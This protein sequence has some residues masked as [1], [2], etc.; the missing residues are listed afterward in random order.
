MKEKPEQDADLFRQALEGVTPL[1]PPDRIAPVAKPRKPAARKLN[2]PEAVP[3][4][5]SDH[6]AGD[7]A[8]TEY[9]RPGLNRM[10]LRKL[11]HGEWR[12]Q[13]EI[14]LHGLNSDAARKLLMEFLH[15][16]T[17]RGLR[18]VNVIHGKGWRSEGRDGILKVLTRHWLAQH[19]QVLA[20]CEAPPQAGGGGA[21]WVLLKSS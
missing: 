7:T 19:P 14:D 18:S 16:A 1:A 17:Q 4:N 2:A 11:R 8:L 21:V 5:L 13:D 6:G 12:V 10:T 3:D 9:L 20:F 15:D